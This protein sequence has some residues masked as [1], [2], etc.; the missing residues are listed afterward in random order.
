MD[1]IDLARE[2]NMR[3]APSSCDPHFGTS[4]RA[5]R[6]TSARHRL[7]YMPKPWQPLNVLIAA[8]QA[9]ASRRPAGLR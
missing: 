5:R 8:E 1:G 6:Q 9:L 2:V 3:L 4:V 7:Y